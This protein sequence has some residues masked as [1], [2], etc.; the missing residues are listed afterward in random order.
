MS[1]ETRVWIH[2]ARLWIWLFQEALPCARVSH[3]AWYDL[4]VT[5]GSTLARSVTHCDRSATRGLA[6]HRS[7]TRGLACGIIGIATKAWLVMGV[8]HICYLWIRTPHEACLVSGV[9]TRGL[10]C[11]GSVARG[12]I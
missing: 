7:V 1:R 5:R 9:G 6:S 10:P 8:S 4:S 3:K 2:E 12:L 11:D